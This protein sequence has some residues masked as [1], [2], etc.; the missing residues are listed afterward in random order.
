[1]QTAI[2]TNNNIFIRA[3]EVAM[4]LHVSVQTGYK[5]IRQLNKELDK[6]GI[7]TS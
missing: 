5:I 3:D 7:I 1:M 2:N 6:K 4:V